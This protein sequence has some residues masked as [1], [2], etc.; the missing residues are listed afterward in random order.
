MQ[1]DGTDGRSTAEYHGILSLITST[2]IQLSVSTL[3]CAALQ[4]KYCPILRT[5]HAPQCRPPSGR[6]VHSGFST[7]VQQLVNADN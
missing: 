6:A 4:L 2:A 7:P 3:D 5:E 1:R